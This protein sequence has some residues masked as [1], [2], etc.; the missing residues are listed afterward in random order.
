M[1]DSDAVGSGGHLEDPEL[2]WDLDPSPLNVP[3]LRNELRAAMIPW[4]LSEDDTDRILLVV[5]E[6]VNNVI[7]HAETPFRV[8]VRQ[9]G[10]VVGIQVHDLSQD[11]PVL[12]D[13]DHSAARGRGLQMVA[14][15]ASEWGYTGDC[16]GKTVWAAVDL[17]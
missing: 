14:G 17:A 8:M 7:D 9:I 10:P 2:C 4:L 11:P 5:N 3:W 6:L 16:D 12:R 15:V 1:S 13:L